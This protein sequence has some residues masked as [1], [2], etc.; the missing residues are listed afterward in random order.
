M[1]QNIQRVTAFWLE[2]SDLTP[3]SLAHR[4]FFTFS[5]KAVLGTFFIQISNVWGVLES[6]W[7]EDLIYGEQYYISMFNMR[8]FNLFSH[9]LKK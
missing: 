7:S 4:H 5:L 2:C 8:Y 6:P 1:D 3:K 9:Y